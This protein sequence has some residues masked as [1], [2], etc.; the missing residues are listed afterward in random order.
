METYMITEEM[1]KDA[2]TYIGVVAKNEWV[3]RTAQSCLSILRVKAQNETIDMDLPDMYKENEEV[4]KR[5]LLG[6]FLNFYLRVA[7]EPVEGTDYLMSADDY[8]RWARRHPFNQMERMKRHPDQAVKQAAFD[9]LDDYRELEHGLYREIKALLTVMNDPVSRFTTAMAQQNSP[10]AW[11]EA[12][13]EL[14]ELM[15]QME[16]VKQTRDDDVANGPAPIE[17]YPKEEG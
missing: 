16:A 11:A 2:N 17:E 13:E 9:I 7:L 3:E 15:R 1:V 14:A 4:K 6:A 8:D 5:F 12:Q 10:Q